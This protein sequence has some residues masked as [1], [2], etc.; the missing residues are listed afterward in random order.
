MKSSFAR[1]C[2]ALLLL[3][4]VRSARAVEFDETR[5]AGKRVTVCRVDPRKERL[6]LFLRDD[7]GQPFERFDP[8]ATCV[9][10]RGQT[11]LF[12]MNA[13]MFHADLGPVGLCVVDGRTGDT[14]EHRVRRGEFLFETQRRVLRVHRRHGPG[15]RIRGVPCPAAGHATGDAIPARCWCAAGR[16]IRPSGRIRSRACCATGSAS[17]RMAT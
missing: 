5:A 12:A 14:P 17:R 4:A 7:A 10:R 3:T 8:L 11:L 2:A 1:C 6:Q 13:G 16:S 15:G 9:R